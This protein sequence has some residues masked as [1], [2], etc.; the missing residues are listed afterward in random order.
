V[1]TVSPGWYSD[2][3]GRFPLR[4]WDGGVWSPYG[5]N[6]TVVLD[7]NGTAPTPPWTARLRGVFRASRGS[8]A[9][10]LAFLFASVAATIFG[11]SPPQLLGELAMWIFVPILF[12]VQLSDRARWLGVVVMVLCGLVAAVMLLGALGTAFTG[13]VSPGES[14][15]YAVSGVLLIVV[16]VPRVRRLLARALPIDPLRVAHLVGLQLAILLLATWVL[17]QLSGKSLDASAY[18]SNGV[19][20]IPLS[21]LPLLV[22]GFFGVGLLVR[23]NFAES[24]ARLGL[25]R[26]TVLQIGAALLL[27]QVLSLIGFGT[28]FLTT[29]L[30]PHTANQL[31]QVSQ[32]LY[33]NFG[34][35][36]LPWVLLAASAGIAEEVLFRG[37]L[38]PRFGLLFTSLLFT[39]VHVQYGFSMILALILLLALVL[40]VLRK[41]ANTTTAIVCH[42]AYDLIAGLQF[43]SWWLLVALGIQLPVLLFVAVRHR[44][45]LRNSV[46]GLLRGRRVWPALPPAAGRA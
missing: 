35:D 36:V 7:P 14:A 4:Y 43:P 32:A 9:I 11:A 12:V 1:L 8:V 6:G 45:A 39:A 37:A 34:S 40:G 38:Q 46:A 5:W 13:S 2:P 28:E 20:D 25:V 18:S 30:T 44:A 27:A 41:I 42:V 33:G 21:E 10:V 15:T 23:R 29:W 26:P 16:L 22:A 31:G 17:T 3:L 19:L 24:A